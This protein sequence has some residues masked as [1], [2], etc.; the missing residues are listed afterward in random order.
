MYNFTQTCGKQALW[1]LTLAPAEEEAA[2]WVV[3]QAAASWND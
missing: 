2:L 3:S 1:L